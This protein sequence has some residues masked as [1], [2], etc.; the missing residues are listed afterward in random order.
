MPVGVLELSGLEETTCSQG[1]LLTLRVMT[2]SD[3]E[4]KAVASTLITHR[5]AP[6]PFSLATAVPISGLHL[7]LEINPPS[8]EVPCDVTLERL[9][10]HSG[11]S[12]P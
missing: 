5:A 8:G 2:R 10:L 9:Q 6:Q 1:A 3:G 4:S 11:E 7:K 12:V